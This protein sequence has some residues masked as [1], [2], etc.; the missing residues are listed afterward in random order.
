[1]KSQFYQLTSGNSSIIIASYVC[2]YTISF[3]RHLISEIRFQIFCVAICGI[4]ETPEISMS[5]KLFPLRM[6]C[7][8]YTLASKLKF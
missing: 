8:L 7:M 5:H 1:M 3:L 4:H 2:S 6:T